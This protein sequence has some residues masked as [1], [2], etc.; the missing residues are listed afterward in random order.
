MFVVLSHYFI[1]KLFDFYHFG[2]YFT[3][4]SFS[5]FIRIEKGYPE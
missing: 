2:K 3:L 1:P 5:S 4:S